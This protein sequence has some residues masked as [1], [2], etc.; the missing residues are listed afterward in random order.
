[1]KSG[2]LSTAA[3]PP[4]EMTKT[5]NTRDDRARIVGKDEGKNRWRRQVIGKVLLIASLYSPD[6]QEA[7]V[8][9]GAS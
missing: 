4:L 8:C 5:G 6:I 1:I 3:T 7:P 9:A 2:D